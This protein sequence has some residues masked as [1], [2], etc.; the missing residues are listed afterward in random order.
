LWN[1]NVFRQPATALPVQEPTLP[2]SNGPPARS[3]ITF[4]VGA[5]DTNAGN[6]PRLRVVLDVAA[7][8]AGRDGSSGM[9]LITA[10]ARPVP[11]T[12]MP[13]LTIVAAK[14]TKCPP[15]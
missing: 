6:S 15:S 1:G 13:A 11:D 12:A 8:A 4:R 5:A 14:S 9:R 3:H 10:S 2:W 7:E